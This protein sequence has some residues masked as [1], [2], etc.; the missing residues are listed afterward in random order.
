VQAFQDFFPG[1]THSTFG[2]DDII[3]DPSVNYDPAS[4]Q[5]VISILDVDLQNLKGYL[6]IAVSSTSNPNGS[7]TKFQLDLTDGHGPLI[8]GN[9]G[10]TLWGDFERFGTSATAYVWTVNMFTFSAGG[11]DQNSLYDH[12]QVIAVDK[13][14][15]AN[16][17]TIDL[18][19]Y[20]STS[21]TIIH[22]NLLPAHMDG[23]TAA[24]GMWFAEETNYGTT[25][26]QANSL[27]LVHV[28]DVLSATPTD[29][30]NFTGTVPVYDFNVV[31]DPSGGNHAWNNGDANTSAVQKGTSDLIDTNDTR[32]SSAFWRVVNGQQ[33][34]VL[35]Q[36]V[37][38]S[39]DPGIAKARWYDFNTTGATDATVNVPLYQSGEIN[40]GAGVFT[41]FPSAD[42]DP[43]GDIGMTYLES[44]TSEYMSMYIAGKGLAETN[45]EAGVLAAGGN[46]A[47]T[48]P[49]GSPHRAGD[50]SGTTVDINTSG[51]P[52]NTFWS[53]NEYSNGGVWGTALAQF[54]MNVPTSSADL[55][56]TASGP[57]SVTIST[58]ASYTITM[59]N[60]GPD[61]AQN[62]VLTDAL[63]A[64]SS[65]VSITPAA[66]NPDSFSFTQSG[67]TVTGT[68]ASVAS[69][70]TDTFTLVVSAP[71]N[72]A[73]GANFSDTASVTSATPDPNSSN[74]SATVSGSI[75]N[76]QSA[77]LSVA[78]SGPSSVTTGTNASYTITLT[79]NGP[80]AAQNVVLTDTLP[81]GSSFVS[82]TPAA[83]NPDSFSF[84]Q[85]GGTV[86]GTAGSVASGNT[87]TFTL[88][89]SAPTNLANGANFSDTASVTSATPD[90][91]SS[92]NS[93]TISGSIVNN[94]S[95]DLSVATGGP[96]TSTEGNTITYSVTVSNS[97]PLDAAK[98]VLTDNLAA[99]MKFVSATT[100]QGTFTHSGSV[101]TFSL[102]T[103]AAGKTVSV[104]VTVQLL[105]DGNVSNSASVTSST[106]DPNTA[107]NSAS[108]TTAV[109]E[110]PII[111]SAPITTT[112]LKIISMNTATFT[113]AN[114]V[115]LPSAFVATIDW[116][117]GTTSQGA[118]AK[119]GALYRVIGSH[120]YLKKSTFT[121]TTTVQE[122]GTAPNVLTAS[123]SVPI[124]AD[125]Q[126]RAEPP[127]QPLDRPVTPPSTKMPADTASVPPRIV[128]RRA[129]FTVKPDAVARDL[130][131]SLSSSLGTFA[132]LSPWNDAE[133]HA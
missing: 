13:S 71:I 23:A 68:A 36:E 53:A 57:S 76:N 27:R 131:F 46:S 99:Q 105:E 2:L 82:I 69:G 65:F 111:V 74:N 43:A 12:V 1:F 24:D 98:V 31:P 60:S 101:I 127:W 87:D 3:T 79:N 73:N 95:A 102:G 72:L 10:S 40:R 119:S 54:A 96:A 129:D 19:S 56:V 42:I 133:S 88:V 35:T 11:I 8:A 6:D 33:H 124:L 64:G 118:V 37:N 91:N 51:A 83:G 28:A 59:T 84:T 121:I 104:T 116:G 85:S 94:Q 128:S 17:H 120:T 18:P 106:V 89:V 50:Y 58:N 126:P 47:D 45:M 86:T 5:W 7:W 123:T 26:G 125:Q 39:A 81:T 108:A 100:S 130:F 34:L 112:N 110:P 109:A 29:F 38:S 20:D 113:H 4:G 48:G 77:D 80:D 25:A 16:V 103:V 32:I 49:D 132:G 41:Y 15:L 66:G 63:P 22:E 52:T 44:S 67:G 9:A 70:N 92:N 90:P 14:N 75:V 107:N 115:E 78:A 21:G 30:V 61:A 93:A 117:D 114:G 97:G 122:A 62:V 55:S